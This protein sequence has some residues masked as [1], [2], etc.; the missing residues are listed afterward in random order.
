MKCQAAAAFALFALHDFANLTCVS[1]FE[2][3]LSRICGKTDLRQDLQIRLLSLS[4]QNSR[5]MILMVRFFDEAAVVVL[6]SCL[7]VATESMSHRENG[8]VFFEFS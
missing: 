4:S 1:I 3:E 7:A 6:F 5:V 8:I 2:A